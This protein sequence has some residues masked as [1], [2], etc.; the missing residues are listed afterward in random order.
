MSQMYYVKLS[1]RLPESLFEKIKN[2]MKKHEH[3]Y[4]SDAVRE[5]LEKYFEKEGE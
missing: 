2:Y 4:V 5:I 1:I 3:C